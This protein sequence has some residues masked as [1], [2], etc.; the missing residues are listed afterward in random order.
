M[1]LPLRSIGQ[2]CV[3]S[4]THSSEEPELACLPPEPGKCEE[5]ANRSLARPAAAS[6]SEEPM[7]SR[8][9]VDRLV[10]RAHKRPP[11]ADLPA[12]RAGSRPFAF[13]AEAGVTHSGDRYA[14]VAL[15]RGVASSGDTVELLSAAAQGGAHNEG[16]VAGFRWQSRTTDGKTTATSELLTAKAAVSTRMLPG[17]DG[18]YITGGVT[19]AQ[20]EFAYRLNDAEESSIGLLSGSGFEGGICIRDKD[21]DG[22]PETCIRIGAGP[23][24]VSDCSEPGP[25][26]PQDHQMG[27][28]GGPSD[29][30]DQ[31][32]M[33]LGA[34]GAPG[35]R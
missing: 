27:T 11:A 18:V 8:R 13:Q 6:P 17:C 3:N 35:Q 12:D 16:S 4:A 22:Q 20:A 31:P 5:P 24:V 28:G 26:P 33:A 2:Q 25:P 10:S 1:P 19:V 9:S 32:R 21:D 29:Y 15:R 23:L 7:P 34:G 30:A 14:D